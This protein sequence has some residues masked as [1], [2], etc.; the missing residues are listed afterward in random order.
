[1][2]NSSKVKEEIQKKL[3]DFFSNPKKGLGNLSNEEIALN[4]LK[5]EGFEPTNKTKVICDLCNK[6]A[7]ID[8]ETNKGGVVLFEKNPKFGIETIC[9]QLCFKEFV[10][11]NP[12]NR[13]KKGRGLAV[14]HGFGID[15]EDKCIQFDL[16]KTFCLNLLEFRKKGVSTPFK[17]ILRP[18]DPFKN[19]SSFEKEK[20]QKTEKISENE[21]IHEFKYL[22]NACGKCESEKFFKKCIRCKLA[23]YCDKNCQIKDWPNHKLICKKL[24]TISTTE[25]VEEKKEKN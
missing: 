17:T 22:C 15:I 6:E 10:A 3:F 8:D 12:E 1:M 9:C 19:F 13:I 7:R 16:E 24:D 4:K 11:V 25:K 23:R 18:N 14:K 5:L 20:A 21:K 2:D